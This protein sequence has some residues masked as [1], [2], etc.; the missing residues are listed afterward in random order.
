MTPRT[1]TS[2][3]ACRACGPCRLAPPTSTVHVTHRPDQRRGERLRFFDG[4]E[5][6]AVD[7]VRH[8]PR[9]GTR[10]GELPARRRHELITKVYETALGTA[11]VP[12]QSCDR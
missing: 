10:Q 8:R 3:T 1:A 9:Q 7:L 2:P 4:R 5:V 11:M 6:V 12:I